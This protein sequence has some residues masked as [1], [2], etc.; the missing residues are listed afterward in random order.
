[1]T[2]RKIDRLDA[3]MRRNRLTDAMLTRE[4]GLSNGLLNKSRNP[5]HDLSRRTIAAIVERYPELDEEWLN[6]GV[7]EMQDSQ[8]MVG[9]IVDKIS[10][11]TVL[12]DKSIEFLLKDII[13]KNHFIEMALEEIA[14]V[15]MLVQK[16][17]EQIDTLLELSTQR[18]A[19]IESIKNALL[20]YNRLRGDDVAERG[21]RRKRRN[22]I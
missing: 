10:S 4:V 8:M 18:N 12:D 11:D 15:N 16:S 13:K 20:E 14:K 3:W 2:V 6:T 22:N 1:M 19:E 17:Q 9:Q 21:S 5:G 7:G